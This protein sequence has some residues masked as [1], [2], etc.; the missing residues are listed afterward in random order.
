MMYDNSNLYVVTKEDNYYIS[1]IS[2]ADLSLYETFVLRELSEEQHINQAVLAD[3]NQ[4]G[5]PNFIF[6]VD[7][8]LVYAY[9]SS[10]LMIY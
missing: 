1:T 10:G 8:S 5:S 4:D 2:T 6:T 3:W 7:D 9:H